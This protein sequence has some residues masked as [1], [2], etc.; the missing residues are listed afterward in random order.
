MTALQ[1]LLG[2]VL[3]LIWLTVAL[4]WWRVPSGAAP[5][6]TRTAGTQ[7]PDTPPEPIDS[8]AYANAQRLTALADDGAEQH[9]AQSALRLADH[10]L[11]LAFAMALRQLDA[12]PQALTVAGQAAQAHLEHA[13]A[14]LVADQRREASL[15]AAA[16]QKS[17]DDRDSLQD[18]LDLAHSQV[19]LDK[20]EIDQANQDLEDAGGNLRRRIEAQVQEHE[21]AE[22]SSA[23]AGANAAVAARPAALP[24][25]GLVRR[26]QTWRVLRQKE[27]ALAAARTAAL[28]QAGGLRVQRQSIVQTMATSTA[29]GAASS[30]GAGASPPAG[31]RPDTHQLLLQTRVRAADQN[32][33]SLI[34]QRIAANLNLAQVFGQWAQLADQK[35]R[36]TLR[37]LLGGVALVVGLMLF[38]LS[39]DLWLHRLV[40]YSGGDRRQIETLRSVTRVGLQV[41][42][43]VAI[44]L[45]LLGVPA[46][47]ATVLGLVGAG[48]TVALKDFIV[49]FIGWLVLMGKNGIRLGDWVEINGVSG[50][51]IEL[52]MF[53]TVLLETGHWSDAGHPTGRRVTFTNSFA[54]E[55]HYF[56]FSTTGQWL[57]DELQLTIPAS[58]DP[59]PIVDT[60]TKL[61]EKAT[62]QGAREAEQEWQRAVPAQR[63]R[64]FSGLPGV[65]VRPVMGGVELSVRYI[66]RANERFQ[67][68]ANLYQAAVDLLGAR[69]P[70]APTASS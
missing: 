40:G 43:V 65:N 7:L 45:V 58:R 38:L 9:L 55:G 6:G 49:A 61:V 67:L 29:A 13:Q 4:L 44:A 36:D 10:Q 60:I 63:G 69:E 68:R 33:L 27:A 30:A 1:K 8:S 21:A 57:W 28:A 22:H 2:V 5:A 34:D 70:A 39:L 64:Q 24:V 66:T 31:G 48:L 47:F 41:V 14:Q 20:F 37:T 25:G 32:V 18:Q 17:T 50:E 23:G 26:F 19:E 42:A 59:K 15:V 51:V 46:Q 35:Q 16:A 11:D 62:A 52:G 12:H 3:A 56:N 53:N 54:I